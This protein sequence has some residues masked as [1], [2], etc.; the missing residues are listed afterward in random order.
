MKKKSKKRK[1]GPDGDWK[2]RNIPLAPFEMEAHGS[3][4]DQIWRNFAVL[5]KLKAEAQ[6]GEEMHMFWPSSNLKFIFGMKLRNY[7]QDR[8]YSLKQLSEKTGLSVSYINEIEKGKK[9]PKAEKILLLAK[10]LEIPYDDL[11]SL[12]MNQGMGSMMELLNSSVLNAF[13]FQLFGISM[14]NILEL[15]S[16]SPKQTTALFNT[17]VE[18]ARTYDVDLESFFLASLRSY[19]EMHDNY[20]EDLEDAA[21]KF[22]ADHQLENFPPLHS[23]QVEELL[24]E[25]KINVVDTDFSD[26]PELQE[27]REVFLPGRPGQ[28]L[29]NSRL[30]PE[31]R[32]FLMALQLGYCVLK[33]PNEKRTT[34]WL[35]VESFDQVMDHFKAS[36][37]AGA[38]LISRFHLEEDLHQFFHSPR[39]NP[40]GLLD[41][42]E[43]YQA[44]PEMLLHRMT[45]VLPGLFGIKELHFLRFDHEQPLN[46]FRLTKELNMPRVLVPTGSGVD[47]HVCRRWLPITILKSFERMQTR[48]NPPSVIVGAQRARFLNQHEVLF[49]SLARSLRL[50]PGTNRSISLGLRVDDRLRE[51]VHFLDDEALESSLVNE[52]CERCPLAEV[53]CS[54]RDAPPIVFRKERLLELRAREMERLHQDRH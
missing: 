22:L 38:L 37:F 6:D 52:T 26:Y 42:H 34:P 13:P 31:Q 32:T 15:F 51:Q 14:E 39:W 53:E 2:Y 48:L 19:Q 33:L 23:V 10:G 29:L 41:L 27:Q 36:Y 17:L 40:Q 24:K 7:R 30:V 54:D 18:I 47:E 8:G 5:H 35:K 4:S 44:T 16:N 20:F 25:F 43:R 12:H 3:H 11:V 46:H 49:I 45:Q 1:K 21:E 28:L 9:Y 50:T